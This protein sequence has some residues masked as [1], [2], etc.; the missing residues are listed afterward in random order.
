MIKGV[1]RHEFHPDQGRALDPSVMLE[2]VLLMKQPISMPYDVLTIRLIL[3]FWIYATN[4]VY[5]SL[6]NAIWKLT[7]SN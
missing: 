3:T 6:T 1:N 5:G 2:D 4:T 7:D